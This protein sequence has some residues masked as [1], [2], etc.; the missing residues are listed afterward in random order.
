MQAIILAAG[1]SKRFW[2]LNEDHK[3]T[4]VLFDAPL[5]IHTL[6]SLQNSHIVDQA[7]VIHAPHSD[8]PT[9]VQNAHLTLPV[10]FLQQ[11]TPD[12]TGKAFS[13]AIPYI[14]GEFLVVWPDMVNV[15][16][17]LQDMSD[18][19]QQN[20]AHAVLL[21]APTG[22]PQ[23]FGM[24]GFQNKVI[25]EVIEKPSPRN[26]PSNIKRVGVEL[27]DQDFIETYQALNEKTEL[28]FIDAINNYITLKHKKVMLYEYRSNIPVLKYPWD[29]FTLLD[30]L[31]HTAQQGDAR[32]G[33]YCVIKQGAT[34]GD[35]VVFEGK[36]Y[37]GKGATIGDNAR[38]VGPVSIEQNAVIEKDSVIQHSIIGKNSH[39]HSCE[40][41][42]SIVGESVTIRENFSL[43]R[44]KN[45]KQT[46][47]NRRV[48]IIV[49]DNATIAENTTSYMG[50]LIDSNI[51]TKPHS[52]ITENIRS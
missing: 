51:R 7:I 8:I 37:I 16:M 52:T 44:N 12:G 48:G 38:I 35:N 46:N 49:G 34:I 33:E 6:T 41:F 24:F 31:K 4:F 30:I 39:I 17:F 13:V 32:I 19:K 27:F 23:N 42:D 26:T 15:D 25:S 2:P 10:R 29:S 47:A 36:A 18:L 5:L 11:K 21:G 1:M 43:V 3:S 45:N 28:A 20:N 14:T 40:L 9:L 50:V 22:T